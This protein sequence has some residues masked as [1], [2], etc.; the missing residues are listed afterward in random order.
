MV[1]AGS[2]LLLRPTEGRELCLLLACSKTA[3]AC[4]IVPFPRLLHRRQ[5]LVLLWKSSEQIKLFLATIALNT[6]SWLVAFEP[7]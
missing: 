3:A 5:G 7:L 4:L 2:C 6:V 1:K